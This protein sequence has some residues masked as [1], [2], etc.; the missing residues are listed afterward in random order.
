[1]RRRCPCT[2]PRRGTLPMVFAV[3]RRLF[4][5]IALLAC[6]VPAAAEPPQRIASLNLCTDQMLMLLVEP[7]RIA[8]VSFLAQRADSSV[9]YREAAAL[10]ANYGRAEEVFVLHP[11]LVL[12]G[13]FTARATVSILERLGKRVELFEPATTFDDIRAQLLRMGDL[14][15]E[16]AKAEALVAAFDEQVRLLERPQHRPLAA[17][18]FANSYTSGRGTL[19]SSVLEAAGLRNLGAE[20]GLEQTAALP[21]EVLVTSRPD[22]VVKG[23]TYDRP[24]LAQEI[25]VHPALAYLDAR[26]EEAVLPDTYMVCGTPHVLRAVQRLADI[27]RQL[28]SPAPRPVATRGSGSATTVR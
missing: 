15:E 18:Y 8:S 4:A 12:A 26:S 10:K 28:G 2:G 9:M 21:L 11:D 1:M 5:V 19:P 27:R 16:R 14:V 3:H 25:F 7:S 23:R 24:A 13:T 17:F 20:L 6:C 22:L